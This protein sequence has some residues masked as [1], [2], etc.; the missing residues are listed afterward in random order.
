MLFAL[1]GMLLFQHWIVVCLGILVFPLMYLDLC[2]ADRDGIQ[3]F[4]DEYKNYMK[5]VPQANFLLG[6]IRVVSKKRT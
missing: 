5:R 6:L 3:K 2:A 4:G 1:A